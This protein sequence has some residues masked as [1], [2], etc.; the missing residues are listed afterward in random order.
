MIRKFTFIFLLLLGQLVRSDEVFDATMI[1]AEAGDLNAQNNIG[2]MYERGDGVAQ[3]YEL[4][5]SWYYKAA[6]H[7]L[8]LAKLNLAHCYH[9]GRGVTLDLKE[10]F[11]W[12]QQAAQDGLAEAQQILGYMY[13]KG[14]GVTQNLKEAF[15]WNA[16]AADQGSL[17]AQYAQGVF[18]E[19]G[20]GVK[21]DYKEAYI[22][23]SVA[24]ANG[25]D[26]AGKARNKIIEKLTKSEFEDGQIEASRIMKKIS[27]KSE[28]QAIDGST[29]SAKF[30][31]NLKNTCMFEFKAITTDSV[32]STTELLVADGS[33]S[34]M[35]NDANTSINF[36]M[37]LGILAPGINGEIVTKSPPYFAYPKSSSADFRMSKQQSVDAENKGYKLFAY[38][39]TT[40]DLRFLED[41]VEDGRF[42]LVSS[43][44]EDGRDIKFPIDLNVRDMNFKDDGSKIPV[45]SDKS[46]KDFSACFMSMASKVLKGGKSKK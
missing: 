43:F 20:I 41:I 11:S 13:L 46:I 1:R 35:I 33:I 26:D 42:I 37:K 14:N 19:G 7:G 29:I 40:D 39:N 5:F 45:L 16:K 9:H 34:Y 8:P 15:Y 25:N 24:A 36:I 17:P 6:K 22:W 44:T 10:A 27:Y 12:Y 2:V 38:Q 23:Y 4:A 32:E 31:S 30:N 3:D 18:Y 28:Y 21:R